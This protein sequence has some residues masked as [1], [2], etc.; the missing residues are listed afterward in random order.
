M[1]V[2]N[3][4]VQYD[5][6]IVSASVRVFAADPFHNETD[7]ASGLL[8]LIFFISVLYSKASSVRARRERLTAMLLT[9]HVL[10]DADYIPL[11]H[12]NHSPSDTV[13]HPTRLES[14]S[15]WGGQMFNN[16]YNA[17]LLCSYYTCGVVVYKVAMGPGIFISEYCSFLL[18]V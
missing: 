11:K 18:S 12:W 16:K 5:R 6:R 8:L 10:H 1:D 17:H 15:V 4:V 3:G 2:A 7:T 13:S 9:V 14:S